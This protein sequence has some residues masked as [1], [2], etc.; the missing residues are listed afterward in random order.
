MG[1]ARVLQHSVRRPPAG[2]RVSID[3]R[4][5]FDDAR[6]SVGAWVSF[7]QWLQIGTRELIVFDETMAEARL[8]RHRLRSAPTP[9]GCHRIVDL[10]PGDAREQ[11]HRASSHP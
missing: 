6:E 10:F 4:F 1:D 8:Q 5:R 9:T 7:Q 11:P 3:F 2:V